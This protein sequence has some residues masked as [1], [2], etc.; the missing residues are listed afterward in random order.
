MPTDQE[1]PALE[2]VAAALKPL[3][4]FTDAL[5]GEKHLTI[6]AVWRL[7]PLLKHIVDEV[8]VVS[9]ED[10]ALSKEMKDI[11]LDKIQTYYVAEVSDLLDKHLYLDPRFKARCMSNTERALA[12][13]KEEAEDTSVSLGL[14]DAHNRIIILMLLQ[15]LHHQTKQRDLVLF[16][17]ESY[18]HKVMNAEHLN[19]WYKERYHE[20]KT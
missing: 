12:Q 3:S 11:I 2:I 8:L 17:K 13:V 4:I 18:H 7:W 20:M 19:N 6:S 5:S 10:S 14:T 1:F 15:L 16:L 9:S